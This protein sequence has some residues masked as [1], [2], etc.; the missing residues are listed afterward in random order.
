MQ[1]NIEVVREFVETWSTLDA[2][3]LASYFAQDGC[4]HNMPTRPVQGRE[5]V[6]EYIRKFIANWTETQWEIISIAASGERVYCERLDRTKTSTG[7][8]DLPCFGVFEMKE[9]KIVEWRDYFD[10]AT[11]MKAVR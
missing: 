11:F 10:L 5:N 4:Y 7:Y 2:R 1:T 3:K 9:G 8:V 6:E